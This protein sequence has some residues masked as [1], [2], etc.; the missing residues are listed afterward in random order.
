MSSR[1]E[2]GSSSKMVGALMKVV[3]DE[4][5]DGAVIKKHCSNIK[6][7]GVLLEVGICR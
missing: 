6:M 7:V 5:K 1:I 4:C 3:D 2:H